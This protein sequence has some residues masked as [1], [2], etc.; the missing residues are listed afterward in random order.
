[1]RCREIEPVEVD[2]QIDF[3]GKGSKARRVRVSG[4]EAPF[5]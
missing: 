1:M 3:L 4:R 2:G 5:V